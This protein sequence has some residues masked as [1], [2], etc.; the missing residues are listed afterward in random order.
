[1]SRILPVLRW[2]L[3][4]T[5]VAFVSTAGIN[6]VVVPWTGAFDSRFHMNYILAVYR[7]ELPD[8][9]GIVS[10][11]P[12]FYYLLMSG[13]VGRLLETDHFTL[14]VAITRAVNIGFGVATILVLAWIG[15]ML[16]G[17]R[18]TALAIALPAISVLITPF[19]RIAGDVYNDVLSTLLC[20]IAIALAIALLKRGPRVPLVLAL[21]VVSVVGMSTRSTFVASFG[22]SMLALIAAF[23]IH[24]SG[25]RARRGL[26]GVGIVAAIGAVTMAVIGWFY[27]RN[28][29]L[30]GSWFRSRP[31][32][33]GGGRDYQSLS[34]NLMNPDYYLVAFARLLGFRDWA[35]WL[36][37]N[38]AVSL[39]ISA[40]CVTGLIIWLVRSARWRSLLATVEQRLI[41]VLLVALLVGVYA[42]QL[43]HATG[44]GNINLRY[45]LPGIVSLGLI[46]AAGALAWER[47]RGQLVTVIL[48][49]LAV[50]ATFD[51]VWNVG[52]RDEYVSTSNPLAHVPTA[53]AENGVPFAILPILLLGMLVGLLITGIALFRATEPA[54]PTLSPRRNLA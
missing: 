37:V 15:W 45:I 5:I 50:G 10:A 29:Q 35:G 4:G 23:A 54:A 48:A 49:I 22:L 27:L 52:P 43:Q 24:G 12:P 6:A 32:Q 30:S 39:V 47:A 13:L 44:W 34:D 3:L 20:V 11:H 31:K 53:L 25:S 21:G 36:P 40:V 14:A 38:G 16:G 18:K 51:V 9:A 8:P 42:M 41:A 1:L 19:I 46:L 33:A 28:Y 26:T 17:A 2:G 7:G